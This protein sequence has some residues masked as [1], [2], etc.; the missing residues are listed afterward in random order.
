MLDKVL[1]L[2]LIS[3]KMNIKDMPLL[4][5]FNKLYKLFPQGK[6]YDG[7]HELFALLS[8]MGTR[9]FNILNTK[10]FFSNI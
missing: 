6:R 8:M 9:Y 7:L 1:V 10:L 3:V 2:Q 4:K 5:H